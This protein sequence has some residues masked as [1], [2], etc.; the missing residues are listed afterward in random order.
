MRVALLVLLAGCGR[1][2]FD[3]RGDAAIDGL[4]EP[5]LVRL[6]CDSAS[7]LDLSGRGNDA[8]CAPTCPT[9]VPGKH[10]NA[11]SFDGTQEL[12]ITSP[13]MGQELAVATWIQFPAAPGVTDCAIN[14]AVGTG[15]ENSW[16]LCI[17]PAAQVYFGTEGGDEIGGNPAGGWHHVVIEANGATKYIYVD[18][19]LATQTAAALVTY[20][21]HPITIGRDIDNGAPAA[22]FTGMLDD[23][24][25]YD[26]M[27][28]PD[29]LATLSTP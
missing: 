3:A 9:V 11:C 24:Y 4:V 29:E 15:I 20:D 12:D 1:L 2:G 13:M 8:H 14:R 26:R 21:T 7:F 5:E 19:Q 17:T 16:Q 6:S 28:T 18:G 10:G 22:G 23:I 25:I 27:L